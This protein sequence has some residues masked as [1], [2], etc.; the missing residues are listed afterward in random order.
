M[1]KTKPSTGTA[2]KRSTR[3]AV[4]KQPVEDQPIKRKREAVQVEEEEDDVFGDDLIILAK[5]A[6]A[7]STTTRKKQKSAKII[8]EDEE[9]IIPVKKTS[10]KNAAT[11]LKKQKTAQKEILVEEEEVEEVTTSTVKKTSMSSKETLE[12][13]KESGMILSPKTASS[14]LKQVLSFQATQEMSVQMA[15]MQD[16][17]YISCSIYF[18][19]QIFVPK[20]LNQQRQAESLL[21]RMISILNTRA[22]VTRN[23]MVFTLLLTT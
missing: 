1:G 7:P 4:V 16:E 8:A 22:V 20:S 9:E 21:H 19:G 15:K 6:A 23:S 14:T 17:L 3:Q 12:A 18:P 10:S 11:A 2:L 13:I 5:P